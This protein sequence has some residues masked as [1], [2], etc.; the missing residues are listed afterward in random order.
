MLYINIDRFELVH[1]YELK[2]F[3]IV[4]MGRVNS[5]NLYV[6]KYHKVHLNLSKF[7]GS[8]SKRVYGKFNM[9]LQDRYSNNANICKHGKSWATNKYGRKYPYP[10]ASRPVTQILK[11]IET[12]SNYE[13][14]TESYLYRLIKN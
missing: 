5:K 12:G 14:H 7:D 2:P 11:N 4:K 6:F 8:Q 13:R 10:S 9:K 3:D 1:T